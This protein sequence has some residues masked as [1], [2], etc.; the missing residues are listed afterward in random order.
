MVFTRRGEDLDWDTP[1]ESA[2]VS[3]NVMLV[4]LAHLQFQ[5]SN[6]MVG[7]LWAQ[8]WQLAP[9]L[10]CRPAP[11]HPPEG[12]P[13]RMFSLD[14]SQTH[15]KEKKKMR[16]ERASSG[17]IDDPQQSLYKWTWILWELQTHQS[18][19]LDGQI[20]FRVSPCVLPCDSPSYN[21]H[22]F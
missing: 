11:F 17:F 8:T 9:T 14:P 22:W 10:P 12:K 18:V 13:E 21:E 19:G 6:L 20:G 4:M 2:M 5:G 7:C 16:G 15:R 3:R 1:Q